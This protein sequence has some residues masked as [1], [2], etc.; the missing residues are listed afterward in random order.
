MEKKTETEWIIIAGQYN[1]E[2]SMWKWSQIRNPAT[3][4]WS[5]QLFNKRKTLSKQRAASMTDVQNHKRV[6]TSFS[7]FELWVTFPCDETKQ[8]NQNN[9][10]MWVKG[11][12]NGSE[13]GMF[14]IQ[15]AKN[16]FA[17]MKLTW[18]HPEFVGL[19]FSSS[20]LMHECFLHTEIHIF[21][22]LICEDNG[23]YLKKILKSYF[24]LHFYQSVKFYLFI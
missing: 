21:K 10:R 23:S 19:Y 7:V 6:R 22:I 15:E 3:A 13:P 8:L 20:A 16:T 12:T 14:Q 18:K 4:D 1:W 5:D 24:N 2:K 9:N 11:A 17:C